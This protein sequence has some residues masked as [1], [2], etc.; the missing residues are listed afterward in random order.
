MK[1]IKSQSKYSCHVL[2]A[3]KNT[4]TLIVQTL[5]K[6]PD[7][8]TLKK[9]HSRIISDPKLYSDTS[10]AIKLMRAYAARGKPDVTRKIFDRISERNNV[11]CNVMIRSYVNNHFYR[12]AILMYKSMLA[13]GVTPDHYTLP[14]VLKASS[15]SD[16]LRF[17]VQIHC[18]AVK[19]GLDLNLFTGNEAQL[20][21]LQTLISL[22]LSHTEDEPEDVGEGMDEVHVCTL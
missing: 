6:S 15:A 5:D 11:I 20:V 18:P 13:S 12:D 14:C 21:S 22:F 9:L 16:D 1:S 19:K 4:E 10:L 17:G 7:V 3:S 8:R 2:T